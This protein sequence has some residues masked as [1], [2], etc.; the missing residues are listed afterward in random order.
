MTKPNTITSSYKEIADYIENCIG[1]E[2]KLHNSLEYPHG[3]MDAGKITRIKRGATG[4]QPGIVF[5]MATF[6][7]G[8]KAEYVTDLFE[9]FIDYGDQLE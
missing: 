7:D 2:V 1:K 3:K 5:F 6:T 8:F 9:F 4:C